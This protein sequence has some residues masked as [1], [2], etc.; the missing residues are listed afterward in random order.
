MSRLRNIIVKPKKRN[1]LVSL[2]DQGQEIEEFY[3]KLPDDQKQ[4][5]DAV[6]NHEKNYLSMKRQLRNVHL[7]Q[8]N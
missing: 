7:S 4:Y 3:S 6:R 8:I 1:A 5:Y 2:N